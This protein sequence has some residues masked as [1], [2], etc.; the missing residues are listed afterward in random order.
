VSL[1][2]IKYRKLAT[3]FPQNE[4]RRD[5]GKATEKQRKYERNDQG[6]VYNLFLGNDTI[7]FSAEEPAI[8][9]TKWASFR[10]NRMVEVYRHM[11]RK[12]IDS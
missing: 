2:L 11:N 5:P 1:P 7:E 6:S 12:M 3:D 4:A 9:N 8:P 10:K